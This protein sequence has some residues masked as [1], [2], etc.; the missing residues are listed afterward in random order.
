[1]STAR[2]RLTRLGTISVASVAL[3][4]S[5]TAVGATAPASG[6]DSGTSGAAPTTLDGIRAKAS[7]DITDRLHALDSAI[8]E[9]NAAEGLGSGQAIVA[10]YLGADVTPLGQLD[11][12]I[13]VDASVKQAARDFSTIFSSYRVYVLV[14]PASRIAADASRVTSTTIPA[15]TADAS[16]AQGRVN[17]QNE[18]QLQPLVDDLDAQVNAASSAANGLA[19]GVLALSPA[20]W[21]ANRDVLSPARSSDRA[22]AAAVAK[23]RSDVQQIHRLLRGSGLRARPGTT[24]TTTG[25]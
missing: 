22:A 25:G 19:A 21:N 23:G 4:G 24:T 16:E 7:T 15:L 14:L 17:P 8:T 18:A 20:Q 5:A 1:M 13:Q 6:T 10:G 12:K 11:Q 3:I 9:V 2:T